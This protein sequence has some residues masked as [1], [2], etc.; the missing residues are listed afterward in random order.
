[1]VDLGRFPRGDPGRK[2]KE[3]I[4]PNATWLAPGVLTAS[5]HW[6]Y[7][8]GKVFLGALGDT[9]LGVEDDRH[10]ISI[11]GS[12][13]GKGTSVIIP[14]LLLYPGSVLCVDPK[15]ENAFVTAARRKALGQTVYALDPFETSGLP[16][17]SFNPL[18][19]IDLDA[20]TCVDDAALIADAIIIQESGSG[21]HFMPPPATGYAGCCCTSQPTSRRRGGI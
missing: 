2:I 19:I 15:G 8:T 7:R 10:L 6:Q 11:A 18:S 3:N 17:A 12:R 21:Q 5:P 14:N 1:M 9:L 16:V 4:A 13:A 20:E